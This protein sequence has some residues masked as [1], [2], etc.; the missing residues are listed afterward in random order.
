[1]GM[2]FLVML[3]IIAIFCVL[4]YFMFFTRKT[5]LRIFGWVA[6]TVGLTF[7]VL[8]ETRSSDI[9]MNSIEIIND[10][11]ALKGAAYYF[12]LDF[13]AWPLPG[14]EAS[15]DVYVDRPMTL[16]K[17]PKYARV[18]LAVGSGDA[19]DSRKLYVGVEL[20][21]KSN[22]MKGIQKKLAG[23]AH[24]TKLLQQPVSGDIYTSGLSVYMRV[25]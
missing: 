7:I 10:L 2:A 14:Q 17:Y 8:S 3:G 6:F 4:Q 20:I 13:E 9:G 19:N 15:L 16:T 24:N 21:P 11:R 18:M 5:V 12:Y 23:N 1:M 25:N 22:G